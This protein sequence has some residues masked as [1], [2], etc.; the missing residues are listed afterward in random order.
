MKRNKISRKQAIANKNLKDAF[1]EYYSKLPIQ[2][3]AAEFIGKDEDTITNWKK[4][5]KKFSDRLARAKS[6]W[7]LNK[8][9]SVKNSQWLLERILKEHFV[10]KK[11]IEHEVNERIEEALDRMAKILPTAGE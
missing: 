7:A 2:K 9:M 3:L 1:I 8:V 6:E 10:E 4:R 11:E 5:D